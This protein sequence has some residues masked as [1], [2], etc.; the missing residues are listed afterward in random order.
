MPHPQ[1]EEFGS[2]E[3]TLADTYRL[4]EE[5]FDGTDSCFDR[6][7]KNLEEISDQMRKM[8]EHVTRLEHGAR[9]PR[10]AMEA[11]GPA[12]TK[13]RE[14]TEGGA[15]AVQAMRG[16]GFSTSRVEPGPNT[17]STS[18]G[19]KAEP[20]ALPC[21][22][23]VVVECGDA[24]SESC[25]P[26][27]ELR[28]PT[29]AG[30]LVPTGET[31]TATETNISTS[32]WFGFA[33]PRRRIWRRKLHGLQFHPPRTTAAASSKRGTSLL[34]PTAGGSLTQ[35]PGKTGPLIQAVCDSQLQLTTHPAERRADWWPLPADRRF[36]SGA[37]V[38]SRYLM[39]YPTL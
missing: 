18:F 38:T 30:G 27:L 39:W 4:C 33:R 13:T 10:L 32:H 1:Q 11:D 20:P 28:S 34:L 2:G 16:D 31:S 35:N 8:D 6:W 14:R 23:Y 9:Q 24:A 3:P 12:D 17:N 5:R 36:R 22:D 21:R 37:G 25:L 26:S 15:T 7:N 19:L 29:A